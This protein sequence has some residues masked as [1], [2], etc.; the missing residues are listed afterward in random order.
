[1]SSNLDLAIVR[2]SVENIQ[3]GIYTDDEVRSRSVVEIMTPSAYDVLGTACPRGLY[4]PYMGPTHEREGSCPTCGN[5][6]FHCPGHAGHVEL[7]VPAYQPLLF[8]RLLQLLR[9]KCLNCHDFRLSSQKVKIFAAK[10]HLLDCGY[11]A[12]VLEFDSEIASRRLKALNQESKQLEDLYEQQTS[13]LVTTKKEVEPKNKMLT[14][15]EEKM[16]MEGAVETFLDQI[17]SIPKP[18]NIKQWTSH[19]RAS[20]RELKKEFQ[21]ACSKVLKCEN[22]SASS[23]KIRHDASN[24][25]FQQPLAHQNHSWNE[26]N[27]IKIRP[28]C[29]TE[30]R[31]HDY[32]SSKSNSGA[33]GSAVDD[34]D[35]EDSDMEEDEDDHGN[36]PEAETN[37]EKGIGDV[38]QEDNVTKSKDN[39][40]H[41]LEVEAQVRLT[42]KTQPFICQHFIGNAHK[43]EGW[44]IFFMRAVPVPP[45]RFRPPM[46]LGTMQVEHSQNLYLNKI[47]QMNDKVRTL[48]AKIQGTDSDNTNEDKKDESNG[49]EMDKNIMQSRAI[50]FWIDLQ[51]NV[52]CLIDSSKD[53]SAAKDSPNGIRQLLEKKEGI[54]RKNMMGKRVNHACRSVISPDPY[55]GTNEIGLPLHFA[56]T[57]TYPTPVTPFNLAEMRSLVRKGPESYPGACWVQLSGGR[58]KI[59]LAKMNQQKREALAARL[60]SG[61]SGSVADGSS[62]PL[63]GR[64]LRDGDMVLMNRQPSLHKPS[65]MAHKVRVLYS[66]TQK[67]IR[68]HY[69]N[70]NT[71]NADYD[72]DEMNC[73]FP[74]NDIARAECEFLARTD[75]QFIVP[76]D[77][78]PLRGLIQDHVDA[79]VKL[80]CK[81]TFL[82]K[83]EFQQLLFAGLSSLSGLEVIPS[84]VD[85]KLIPPAMVK[86]RELWT[87]KQLFSALLQHLRYGSDGDP[88]SKEMLPGISLERKTKTPGNAFGESM[89]EHK[90]LIRDGE[91]LRGVL[92][93]AA[94]GATDF[95]LV[96]AVY[97]AYGPRKAGLLLNA[98]GRLCTA[99]I[100][101]YSGHS[102]RM[103]DLILTSDAD[104]GRRKLVKLAY[105]RGSRAAKAWA[106]SDGGKVSIPPVEKQPGSDQPLKPVEVAL[107]SAK[108][109]ELLNGNEGAENAASLDSYMQS[110]LNPLTSDIIKACLPGGLS[111]PFPHNTFSL[112]VTTGAKG[113]TVNQ[114]QVSCALGQQALEGRRVPR[115]SSGRTLPSFAP[116]DISPRADGFI[117]DRFL[118]GIRPQE[119]YFH[120]MAGREGLVDTAVKTSRSGYLQRCLVKHLEELKVCY[121]HTVRDGEGSV[122]QFLYGEDGID[123]VKAAHLDG[124]SRTLQYM[125]RNHKSLEKRH[126]GLPGCTLDF[127]IS[128]VDRLQKI[129]N[130]DEN[131]L[132]TE[133]SYVHAKKLRFGSKW[134]RGAICKGWFEAIIVK[135][136]SDGRNFDLKYIKE[137]K[138]VKNVPLEVTFS[139]A[140]TKCTRAASS[141]CTIVKPAVPDPIISNCIPERGNHR[142]GSSG[143]CVSE[144]VA[145]DTANAIS[146]DPDLRNAI[147]TLGIDKKEM[148]RIVAAKFNSALCSPGE[149]VGSIAAQSVGEPSTQMTLNTFHLAGSGA[150]VTLGIPR[151]R[152]IIMTASR[153][154]KTPTM[155]VPLNPNVSEREALRLTRFFTKLSLKEVLSS[156]EGITVTETLKQSSVGEW[157]RCYFVKLKLH[158]AERINEAFGLSLE[159]IASVVSESLIP[160]I[161]KIMKIELKRSRAAGEV[162]S[163]S[164][165][166][167]EQSTYNDVL[168]ES[169]CD[170]DDDDIGE[171]DG[172]NAQRFGRK[173]QMASYGEMDDEDKEIEAVNKREDQ[174]FTEDNENKA[175]LVTDD[176]DW[177]EADSYASN[178]VKIDHESNTLALR[179]LR[180]DPAARPLLMVGLI[181]RA[182]EK[183]LV[184]SRKMIDEAFI[185]DEDGRGRCLQF[186]GINFSEIWNLEEVDHN[187]IASNDIWAMRC[188]Y[189]VEA[190]CLNIVEQ[191]RSV[192]G[193]YG[194]SVDPR[195]LSL[196]ADYMTFDGGFRPMNRNGMSDC[197]SS[198]LQ[199]SFETTANFMI[200]AAL[201]NT[202]DQ[203]IS[204]SANIVVG[205]PM[206][207]GTGAFDCL[208]KA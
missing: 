127:A 158:S 85:M 63:V 123:P 86:P 35:S 142:I 65:I 14:K 10:F 52:N 79:G 172:V 24:K 155:S 114:S 46:I 49:A 156:Q 122:I 161:A 133:G 106:D 73:H 194:I 202:S 88:N 25:I 136:H 90:V 27:G 184:R 151:L 55:I 113:S 91:L 121:D 150:N 130:G 110:Q 32:N 188:T 33:N 187:R 2:R 43:K 162:T 45:S 139:Y 38:S 37:K 15:K 94:Y 206:R 36:N 120:C 57:L 128:D 192:F 19:E 28:A 138:L 74:Q 143:A 9:L 148:K 3:F 87:G 132:L 53:P 80:C 67:T 16:L 71:Y 5:T 169:K 153:T 175:A 99:Y 173:K 30:K 44:G 47:I 204:P 164:V 168:K 84:D 61:S 166:G 31:Q 199:M 149:A 147:K 165:A 22:C 102:C 6:Y 58:G 125:A 119:Y 108:I 89:M 42:W 17:L 4:D 101:Y 174:M 7:C 163:I 56:K 107:A 116:Y 145:S 182:A 68:M 154:L 34:W 76:T 64:Q 183:T 186:A 137:R 20:F 48:F 26:S 82:E 12:R 105:N 144:K 126:I 180:V 98:L 131:D 208:I 195:H 8:S 117:T 140:G 100:Q 50:S 160:E 70:C 191:I 83:W 135:V 11:L 29:Y 115:M 92:D 1:M 112:M 21:A 81:D 171:E 78:S 197:S 77:G 152:E 124:S 141:T 109:G 96:H 178:A 93:K 75:L 60:L 159:N 176:E 97:E 200:D 157:E 203:M 193:V 167:G 41:A 95:S 207:H 118:T 66:P 54:F 198:F 190:A 103:E 201:N 39:F 196:I 13:T 59:D 179:P 205:R 134:E 129:K 189:G 40:M 185:N 104:E 181:E 146:S 62:L 72:G 69:A 177:A 111:V 23:P 51:T 18:S 170:D